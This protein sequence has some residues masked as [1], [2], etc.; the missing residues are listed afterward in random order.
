MSNP[1]LA[2]IRQDETL[3]PLL[4]EDLQQI[5]CQPVDINTNRRSV[6]L[7]YLVVFVHLCVMEKIYRLIKLSG[8]HNNL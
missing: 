2:G 4:E 3:S 8:Y 1:R 6:R 5:G 7:Q